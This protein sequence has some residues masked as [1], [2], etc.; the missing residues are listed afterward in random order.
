MDRSDFLAYLAGKGC[1]LIRTDKKGYSVVRNVI[2]G[3]S[4]GIPVN[5]PLLDATVCRICKTLDIEFP[6]QC[7]SAVG[8]IE[9]AHNRHSS[10][11]D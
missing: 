8:V 7:Q 5:D 10:E 3:K 9:L 11:K 2:S 4:S 1:L 6:E